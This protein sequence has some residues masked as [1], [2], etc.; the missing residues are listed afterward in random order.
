MVATDGHLGT[1]DISTLQG[2]PGPQGPQ[3]ATGPIGPVGPQGPQGDTG[4]TG[5]QGPAGPITT[6]SIVMLLVVNGQAP[7]APLG[8][9]LKGYTFLAPR[10]NGGGQSI[11]YA[12]YAKN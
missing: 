5:Q 12:V 6:G 8:Y 2:P 4:A 3:G 10:P 7:P 9:T 11:G 1:A